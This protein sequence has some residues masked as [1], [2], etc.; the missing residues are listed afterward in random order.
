MLAF[1]G[2]GSRQ[3]CAARGQRAS[4]EHLLENAASGG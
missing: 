2:G 3:D 4:G 1:C